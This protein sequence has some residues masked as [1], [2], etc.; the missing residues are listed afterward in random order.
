MKLRGARS[1][2]DVGR[3][4]QSEGV[5]PSQN[6]DFG[7]VGEHTSTSLHFQLDT[8]GN[9]APNKQGNLALDVNDIS[10]GD[11]NFKEGTVIESEKDALT[12]IYHRILRVA[13][14]QDWPLDEMFFDGFGFK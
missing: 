11:D 5:T 4:L 13:R 12:I 10:V 6:K 1:V 2:A 7:P 9:F 3:W 8:K 14:A